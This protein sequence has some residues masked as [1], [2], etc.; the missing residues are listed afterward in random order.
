MNDQVWSLLGLLSTSHRQGVIYVS[1]VLRAYMECTAARLGGSFLGR[2]RRMV[3]Y[4]FFGVHGEVAVF[5]H[6]SPDLTSFIRDFI[7]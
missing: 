4:A 2:R 5:I 1:L 7:Q 3:A 6:V